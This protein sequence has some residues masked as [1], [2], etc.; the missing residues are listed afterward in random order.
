MLTVLAIF[1]A[2]TTLLM[3]AVH[4]ISGVLLLFV[5][6]PIIDATWD[7]PLFLEMPLTQI[8]SGLVPI[9]VVGRMFMAKE[10]EAFGVMPLKWLWLMYVCYAALSS[11]FILYSQDPKTAANIFFRY[12]N[13]L[14]GFYMLQAF[15][16]RDSHLK[17]IFFGM[18]LGGLFPIG[19]GL[20]QL[21]TGT[22]WQSQ[23]IE[24]ITRNIG[25]YHDAIV[26]RQYALQTILATLLFGSLFSNA[27]IIQLTGRLV[28]LS[29]ATLVMAKAYSKAGFLTLGLWTV[30]WNGLQRRYA[31][32]S[33][34][35]LLGVLGGTYYASQHVEAI[36][37]I[38]H[39]EINYIEG[40]GGAERTF[41]GRWYVWQE[42]LSDWG[43]LDWLAR[44]FG[45]GKVALGA[46]NDFL[47]M[48]F[49]GGVVGLLVYLTLLGTIGFR[50]LGN[51]WR[52][53]DPLTIASLMVFMAWCVDAIGL[54]PSSYSGYQWFIWGVI[55]LSLRR[56]ILDSA[57]LLPST[58]ERDASDSIR[59]QEKPVASIQN[60]DRVRRFPILSDVIQK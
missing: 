5:S 51:L 43:K 44:T 31:S 24:G 35:V 58:E 19:I 46:H 15:F 36:S 14:A 54:V 18:M 55:G 16:N 6:K 47:L 27:H 29:A 13:G 25:L 37:Q 50:I 60:G 53:P 4:P 56:R 23:E 30:C 33:I 3:L 1:L 22:T 2:V 38:F 20:Y 45:S 52:K 40:T 39:K 17:L 12:L 57:S 28:Y 49:H 34:L 7:V 32:L 41:N 10:E 8:I 9:V 11:V 21:A 26:I 42:M 59:Y 48:L